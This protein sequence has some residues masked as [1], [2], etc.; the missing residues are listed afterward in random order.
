M[1]PGRGGDKKIIDLADRIINLEDGRL[2]NS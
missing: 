1:L 2:V